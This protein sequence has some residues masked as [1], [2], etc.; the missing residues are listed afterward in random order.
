M[1]VDKI[2]IACDMGFMG[3][4]LQVVKD[5]VFINLESLDRI[6]KTWFDRFKKKGVQRSPN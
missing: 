5:M 1:C 2:L 3:P 6:P 4:G